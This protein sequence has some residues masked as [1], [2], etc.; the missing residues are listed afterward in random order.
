[1][2]IQKV[3][4]EIKNN[5]VDID[6][7]ID[8]CNLLM[9]YYR[10]SG[11]TQGRIEPQ[12]TKK[13]KITSTPF[14]LEK[15]ALHKRNNNKY[16][17]DQIKKIESLTGSTFSFKTVGKADTSGN[18]SCTCNQSDF[19]ILITNYTSI[20]SPITCGTCNK[21]IPLYKLPAYYDFGYMPVLS[22]N[23]NY[24]S[25]DHLQMNCEV[26]EQWALNQMQE[27]KSSLSKQGR[28]ICKN[29]ETLTGIPTF[30]YLHNYRK[31]KEADHKWTCP[32]CQQA[33][34][35]K[36]QLHDMYDFKCD[37]CRI[38]SVTSPNT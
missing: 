6:Q 25:C 12:Y 8:E 37:P 15:N 2:Y 31:N 1:M 17:T 18:T 38:I 11:Q 21:T 20:D 4:I 27:T 19:Y 29:I 22:W 24:Q 10:G 9:A 3:S 16:V 26:G 32:G 33:W 7:I 5:K 34:V 13:N 14:T 23:T 35:L 30:Y 28:L 36:E